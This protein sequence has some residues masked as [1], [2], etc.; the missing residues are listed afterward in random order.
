MWFC[1]RWGRCKSSPI[2]GRSGGSAAEAGSRGPAGETHKC[3]DMYI[4]KFVDCH[5]NSGIE[6][7]GFGTFETN[8]FD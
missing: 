5:V 8:V 1:F 6:R 2:S 4:C 7:G 3:F